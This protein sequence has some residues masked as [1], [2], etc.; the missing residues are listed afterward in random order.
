[1]RM[2]VEEEL[3]MKFLED[4]RKEDSQIKLTCI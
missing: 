2:G 1:M 3:C 4:K